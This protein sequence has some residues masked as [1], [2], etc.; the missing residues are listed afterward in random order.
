MRVGYSRILG[1][2]LLRFPMIYK[3]SQ[4]ILG[5]LRL[6]KFLAFVRFYR[7]QQLCKVQCSRSL[8]I[9]QAAAFEESPPRVLCG[10][11][12]HGLTGRGSAHVSKS[13][14]LFS[15]VSF[16]LLFEFRLSWISKDL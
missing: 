7:S 16:V 6:L 10:L 14:Y 3:C 5:F 15:F 1:S 13:V 4:A 2:P 12:L 8:S 9:E 11:S